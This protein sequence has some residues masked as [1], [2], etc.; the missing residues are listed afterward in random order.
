MKLKTFF[1]IIG[2]FFFTLTFAQDKEKY[3]A[4][5]NEAND[6]YE[7]KEFAKS[8]EKFEAAFAEMEDKGHRLDRYNA[9]CSWAL[10]EETEKAFIHLFRYANNK[11]S[12]GYNHVINDTDLESLHTD[13]RWEEVLTQVK[14]NK[15]EAEKDFDKE[16]VAILDDV[17]MEDQKYRR[18]LRKVEQE[19]GKDSDEMKALWE[20]INEKDSENLVKVKKIL[21]EKGWLGPDIIGKSGNNTLF[22]VIQH[23]DQKTQE[24]YLP[25][26]REAVK[27]GKARS[28]SLAMLEDR[29]ANGQGKRQIYG[30]QMGRDKE[31]GEYFVLPIQDPENVEARRAEAG[32]IPL[33]SY[34]SYY[35]LTWDVEKH[36]ARTL[37]YEAAQKAKEE[38]KSKEVKAMKKSKKKKRKK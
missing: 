12:T 6:L 8:G 37:K 21:D 27:N 24:Q 38:G 18:Q 26:M 35:D 30:S 5:I 15:E 31:T 34:V 28:S 22:L 25:M 17:G 1:S 7:T 2:I 11:N 29:V 4:L 32:M 20:T 13:K 9:S 23:S 10:A 14:A 36:K 16:L 33:A 19:H 3:R